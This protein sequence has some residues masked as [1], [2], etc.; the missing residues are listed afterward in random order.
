MNL[1]ILNGIF[2]LGGALALAYNVRQIRRDKSI[3]G[4]HWLP[5]IWFSAW[6][7]FNLAYYPSLQQWFSFSGG[8]AIVLVNLTW[9]GHVFYYSN[10][11]PDDPLEGHDTFEMKV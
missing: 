4:V 5:T 7:L 9:L 3:K 8:C 2:E 11:N 10:N 1:D 6:G